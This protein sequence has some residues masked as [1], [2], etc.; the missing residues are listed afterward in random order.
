MPDLEFTP[1]PG[2]VWFY[3]AGQGTPP[4][5]VPWTQD[6]ACVLLGGSIE[7][8]PPPYFVRELTEVTGDWREVIA[9]PEPETAGLLVFLVGL[10]VIW[11]GGKR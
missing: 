5:P 3:D 1:A 11:K 4:M 9:V 10:W 8:L 2:V 7:D 6:P